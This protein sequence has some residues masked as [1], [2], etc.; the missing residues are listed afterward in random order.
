MKTMKTSFLMTNA[1]CSPKERLHNSAEGRGQWWCYEDNIGFLAGSW[2]LVLPVLERLCS[3][4]LSSSFPLLGFQA[5]QIMSSSKSKTLWGY[6]VCGEYMEKLAVAPDM[7]PR[8][9]G[10]GCGMKTLT[11]TCSHRITRCAICTAWAWPQPPFERSMLTRGLLTEL[12]RSRGGWCWGPW[13]VGTIEIESA[14][15]A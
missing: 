15:W 9:G 8:G 13:T 12:L 3:L 1:W 10:G 11:K 5:A 6:G 4:T 14:L 7:K 2:D